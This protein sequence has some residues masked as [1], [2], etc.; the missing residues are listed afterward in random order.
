MLIWQKKLQVP[1]KHIEKAHIDNEDVQ[2]YKDLKMVIDNYVFHSDF[3][4]SDMDNADVV[5][6]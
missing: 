4:A 2:V 6:E 5:L 1:S 3:Y